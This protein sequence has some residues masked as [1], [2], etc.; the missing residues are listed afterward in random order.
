MI[1]WA[2]LAFLLVLLTWRTAY[3]GVVCPT[4]QG[5][6]LRADGSETCGPCN[7]DR[8][9][10]GFAPQPVGCV[11]IKQGVLWDVDAHSR[12]IGELAYLRE[13]TATLI[14]EFNRATEQADLLDKRLVDCT[15]ELTAIS[16]SNAP[17]SWEVLGIGI[18][19][20]ALVTGLVTLAF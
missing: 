15:A 19:A 11:I 12:L 7:L 2:L 4:G 5:V 1:R 8:T 13:T 3:A 17:F 10:L 14:E 16:P 18:I 9:E 6:W 20:G